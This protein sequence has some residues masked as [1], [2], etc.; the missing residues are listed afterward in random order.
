MPLDGLRPDE[1]T[2]G[3]PSVTGDRAETKRHCAAV[4]QL[5][6]QDERVLL[7]KEFPVLALDL[8]G[9]C[10]R[11]A[12]ALRAMGEQACERDAGPHHGGREVECLDEFMIEQDQPVLGIEQA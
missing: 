7:R 4:G 5:L 11:P 6:S 9:G 10:P 1:L 2:A 12:P 3:D 8:G